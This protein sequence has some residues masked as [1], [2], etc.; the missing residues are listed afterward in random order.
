MKK[1]YLFFLTL[2]MGIL[3]LAIACDDDS[4]TTTTITTDPVKPIQKGSIN[5]LPMLT[6]MPADC[7]DG[8]F[9]PVGMPDRLANND[10]YPTDSTTIVGWTNRSATEGDQGLETNTDIIDH[11]WALWQSL[12]EVTDQSLCDR[13]L[14]RFETWYTPQDVMIATDAGTPLPTQLN[15]TGAIHT[16]VK[17]ES[18]EE[19]H[20]ANLRPQVGSVVG[21]VKYNPVLARAARNNEYFNQNSMKERLRPGE[22]TTLVLPAA[23]VMLKPVYRILSDLL[24]VQEDVYEIH[25]W[26][27]KQ[28]GGIPDSLFSKKI[29]VDISR[30]Q[31]YQLDGVDVY[32]VRHFIHHTL[33]AVE[34]HEYNQNSHEGPERTYN[35]A[36]AGDVMLLMGMHVA[37]RETPRWTWQSFYWTPTPDAPIF[38][39]SPRM[40]RGRAAMNGQLT[41]PA[42]H[43]A[44][45]VGY[46]M[47]APAGPEKLLSDP[48]FT[49]AGRSSVY[50]LNPY[51]E[52]TFS[53]EVFPNQQQFY[54]STYNY[55]PYAGIDLKTFYMPQN[56]NGITSSCIGCH[57]QATYLG[58]DKEGVGAANF[59][60][61]QYVPRDAPW[62]VGQLQTDF[63]WS[64]SGSYERVPKVV[65]NDD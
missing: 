49:L 21:K 54:D 55:E 63:A 32:A 5:T 19:F 41:A 1:S 53:A 37:T 31:N 59:I 28:D 9:V 65:A 27:G 47:V 57:S 10:P 58:R 44:L 16:R 38:P 3:F 6:V 4:T 33:S 35:P 46:S 7:N 50:A 8:T 23:S 51:I 34:A 42:D 61:D 15:S 64:L 25:I 43:Y 20:G 17:L 36:K 40:A 11:A 60:A 26:G 30:E 22:I 39:S 14:R 62:F 12:T 13:P 45:T 56:I 24:E 48:D 29:Y 52:G 18:F 2:V